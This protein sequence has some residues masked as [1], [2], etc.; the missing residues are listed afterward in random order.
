MK[1][2]LLAALTVFIIGYSQLPLAAPPTPQPQGKPV[3]Q[4]PQPV[5]TPAPPAVQR[6]VTQPAVQRPAV[7][8]P[9]TQNVTP[10]PVSSPTLQSPVQKP[11]SSTV[12]KPTTPQI[13]KT[14]P[15]ATS[16][17]K[18]TFTT[19]PTKSGPTVK[20]TQPL[21]KP[22]SSQPVKTQVVPTTKVVQPTLSSTLPWLL[23]STTTAVVPKTKTFS[24]AKGVAASVTTEKQATPVATRQN[25]GIDSSL[26][27]KKVIDNVKDKATQSQSTTSAT[28][29]DSQKTKTGG[30]TGL[31]DKEVGAIGKGVG[32][33]LEKA[34]FNL[35]NP[36]SNLS[37]TAGDKSKST[38]SPSTGVAKTDSQKKTS[39]PTSTLTPAQ[40]EQADKMIRPEFEKALKISDSVVERDRAVLA[41]AKQ[42]I[43]D[44]GNVNP[45]VKISDPAQAARYLRDKQEQLNQSIERR[46][47]EVK[48]YNNVLSGSGLPP[49]AAPIVSSVASWGSTQPVQSPSTS[50]TAGQQSDK[51]LNEAASKAK[52]TINIMNQGIAQAENSVATLSS[53]MSSL[54]RGEAATNLTNLKNARDELA[55][56]TT[57][58]SNMPPGFSNTEQGQK[59]LKDMDTKTRN[60]VSTVSQGIFEAEKAASWL[61]PDK[62]K[63]SL[64]IASQSIQNLKNLKDQ[65][66]AQTAT[67]TANIQSGATESSGTGGKIYGTG[68]KADPFRDYPDAKNPPWMAPYGTGVK[69]DPYRDYEGNYGKYAPFKETQA[70]TA[71]AQKEINQATDR[72]TVAELMKKRGWGP[73]PDIKDANTILRNRKTQDEISQWEMEHHGQNTS[74]N[75]FQEILNGQAEPALK[76]AFEAQKALKE[77]S[78]FAKEAGGH[79]VINRAFGD[80]VT[81]PDGKLGF[82][83]LKPDQIQDLSRKLAAS[84]PAISS[85]YRGFDPGDGTA[86]SLNDMAAYNRQTNSINTGPAF[87]GLSPEQQAQTMMHEYIG[88][89]LGRSRDNAVTWATDNVQGP[90]YLGWGGS[91]LDKAKLEEFRKKFENYHNRPGIDKI[92]YL[93][94]NYAIAANEA[95][96][97]LKQLKGQQTAIEALSA[98][99]GLPPGWMPKNVSNQIK[100]N[101]YGSPAEALWR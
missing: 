56:L 25:I 39:A 83:D 98:A 81:L 72:I 8:T 17:P 49:L 4:T 21:T 73:G 84:P 85:L 101:L 92:K 44:G 16:V 18:P 28:K 80:A 47:N 93:G 79:P 69:N 61:S 68:T 29:S 9:K 10:R 46:N 86:S 12:T 40:K 75:S 100:K 3:V 37:A 38:S 60:A 2:L 51:T 65:L 58:I 20:T 11:S 54:A 70:M 14:Q 43:I 66:S 7:T 1:R 76:T 82:A 22:I 30:A 74:P 52:N 99:G 13:Q 55:T 48:Q 19:T 15:S 34:G 95:G 94:D 32:G 27:A 53:K 89:F 31:T 50:T 62:D 67:A 88:H 24:G 57:K 71:I 35:I 42:G 96:Y 36:S 6:P 63:A 26:V 5:R 45:D 59:M 91:E 33:A 90:K 23:G 41:K 97:A 64:Q 87:I 78:D 77:L